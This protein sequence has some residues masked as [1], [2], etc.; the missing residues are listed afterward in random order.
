VA[1]SELALLLNYLH[2]F[3]VNILAIALLLPILRLYPLLRKS[4]VLIDAVVGATR[5]VDSIAAR[6]SLIVTL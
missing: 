3:D 2:V 1:R 5:Q 6:V 4:G